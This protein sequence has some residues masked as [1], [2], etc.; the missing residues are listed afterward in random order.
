MQ[1]D[2]ENPGKSGVFSFS[3]TPA[4]TLWHW[5]RV[6]TGVRWC[7]G[8]DASTADGMFDPI[9][10]GCVCR[11]RYPSRPP[12]RPNT[13]PSPLD[14][15]SVGVGGRRVLAGQ[16][17]GLVGQS[18]A[19]STQQAKGGRAVTPLARCS[20]APFGRTSPDGRGHPQPTAAGRSGRCAGRGGGSEEQQRPAC[21]ITWLSPGNSQTGSPQRSQSKQFAAPPDVLPPRRSLCPGRRHVIRGRPDSGW[22]QVCSPPGPPLHAQ[23]AHEL[24]QGPSDR[25]TAPMVRSRRGRP[26][27][28]GGAGRGVGGVVGT[29][30]VTVARCRVRHRP[31]LGPLAPGSA[32][33][34]R[35]YRA[36]RR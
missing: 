13:A 26:A 35:Q 6:S 23:H 12:H 30:P 32:P 31:G 17:E 18:H 25:A 33:A 22:R 11:S 27:R 5:A 21:S 14:S 16:G 3:V 2:H 34:A 15:P 36:H 28:A 4:S 29:P 7:R 20:A 10:G 9:G 8:R 24:G 19:G 1:I